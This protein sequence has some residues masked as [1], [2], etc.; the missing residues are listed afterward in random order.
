LDSY[1]L[2]K[3]HRGI[4]QLKLEHQVSSCDANVLRLHA[5]T[6]SSDRHCNLQH[7]ST[8]QRRQELE[9]QGLLPKRVLPDLHRFLDKLF[10][11]SKAKLDRKL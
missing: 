8:R 2:Q 4:T 10:D 11:Y 3:D 9:I 1:G 7:Y 5:G 6:I